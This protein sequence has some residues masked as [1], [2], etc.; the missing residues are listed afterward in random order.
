MMFCFV[1]G[2]LVSI[3]EG[4]QNVHMLSSNVSFDEVL[5]VFLWA[6][7]GLICPNTPVVLE[8]LIIVAMFELATCFHHNKVVSF[9]EAVNGP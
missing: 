8:I 9:A 6:T 5:T 2:R 1:S 4:C 7:I 3:T